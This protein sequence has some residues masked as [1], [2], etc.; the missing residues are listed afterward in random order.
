MR[1][2][3]ASLIKKVIADLCQRANFKL[4]PD[5]KESL[6]K[7]YKK[8]KGLA[9][10]ALSLIFKNLKIAEKEKL[11]MCQDTGMAVI[12]LKIGQGVIIKGDLNSAIQNGVKEGYKKGC[13]RASVVNDPV[14]KRKNTFTN[15]P[16]VIHEEI[17]KGN[18]IEITVFPKG[19]GSENTASLKMFKP[20]DS[21]KDIENFITE[22]V[23]VFGPNA[24]PPLIVGVGIGGTSEKCMLLAKEAL[25]R[26]IGSSNKNKDIA[27]MEKRILA[28]INLLKIGPAGF[29]GK[30]TA[31]AVNIETFPT[32]IAGLPVAI[33]ISCWAL[34]QAKTVL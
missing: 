17:V 9:K 33:N 15:T 31:L 21:L 4:R 8:E 18:K 27:R 23:K 34:R 30:T 5:V 14:F 25:L 29:G 24:C 13:L 32:H 26:K 3:N 11:A 2:I 12:F 6:C 28:K 19:F 20:S 16:A 22:K 10:Y 7:A 1:K